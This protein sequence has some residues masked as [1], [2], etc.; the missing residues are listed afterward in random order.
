MIKLRTNTDLQ[1]NPLKTIL[2]TYGYTPPIS[3]DDVQNTLSETKDLMKQ[4][5]LDIENRLREDS[6][7]RNTRGGRKTIRKKCKSNRG[8][9]RKYN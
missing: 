6:Q 4:T 1:V 7:G 9:T 8:I 3:L 5:H 2:D